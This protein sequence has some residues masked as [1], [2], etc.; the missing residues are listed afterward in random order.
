MAK[1]TGTHIRYI[2][3]G[4]KMYGLKDYEEVREFVNKVVEPWDEIPSEYWKVMLKVRHLMYNPADTA[5]KGKE[6]EVVER[7]QLW[8]DMGKKYARWAEFSAHDRRRKDIV[9]TDNGVSW[10][11]KTTMSGGDFLYSRSSSDFNQVVKAYRRRKE[12]IHFISKEYSIDIFTTWGEFF[13][14]LIAYNPEK[15]LS[16]WFKTSP[17]Y[18]GETCEN[19]FKMQVIRTSKKKVAYLQ[20]WEG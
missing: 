15:G 3:D 1:L 10:D 19:V 16:T 6:T 8:R 9:D 12:L 13:D 4:I 7:L 20:S 17:A 11:V 5:I 14:F 2:V 18:N